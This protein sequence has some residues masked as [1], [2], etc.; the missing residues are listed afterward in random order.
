[1]LNMNI[2][3]NTD[4]LPFLLYMQEQEQKEKEADSGNEKTNYHLEREQTTTSPQSRLKE[5]LS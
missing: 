3:N 5:Y 1:M 2:D 4:S